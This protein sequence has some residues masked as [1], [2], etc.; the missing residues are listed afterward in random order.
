MPPSRQTFSPFRHLALAAA[1]VV[2]SFGLPAPAAA[3]GGPTCTAPAEL[4]QFNR[5]LPRLAERLAT[6]GPVTIVAIGSS[7]TA[8]AGASSAAASYPARLEAA[9]RAKYPGVA[10]NV[11]NRGVNGEEVRDM[12]ARLDRSVLAE[13]PDLVLW[14]L[15]SNSVLRDKEIG[16]NGPLIADAIKRVRAAGADL[17]LIDPQYAPKVLARAGIEPMLRLMSTIAKEA[18]V[19]LFDRFAIM[20]YWRETEK[21]PFET[22]LAPDQL[23]L[24][25]WGYNCWAK[26]MADAIDRAAARVPQTASA[27]IAR[28]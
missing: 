16:G 12:L 3:Q 17:V 24:N 23:H 27:P 15:G 19:E 18:S 13:K 20:R 25:D 6:G 22:F 10:I 1:L 9:L 2:P 28:R 8:G 14:Q 5:T 21:I 26:L 4:T 7:S 11:L